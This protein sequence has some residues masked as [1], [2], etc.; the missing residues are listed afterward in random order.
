MTAFQFE[1]PPPP[2]VPVPKTAITASAAARRGAPRHTR[3]AST[4]N[5]RYAN[6]SELTDHEGTF[7]PVEPGKPQPLSMNTDRTNDLALKASW[8]TPIPSATATKK[9]GTCSSSTTACA[10]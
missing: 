8:L 1:Y 4:G 7:H 10:G 2:G 9:S 6:H 3:R 5:M